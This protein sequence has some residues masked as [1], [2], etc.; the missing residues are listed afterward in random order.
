MLKSKRIIGMTSSYAA[1]CNL[2][3]KL[4]KTPIGKKYQYIKIVK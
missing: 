2:L 4:L 3:I 1:K